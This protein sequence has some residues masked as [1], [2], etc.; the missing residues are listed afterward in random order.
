MTRPVTKSARIPLSMM[1]TAVLHGRMAG[2]HDH[3]TA[4]ADKV[5]SQILAKKSC[6]TRYH[7]PA[8]RLHA[9]LVFPVLRW[10]SAWRHPAISHRMLPA[11]S[12]APANAG[13]RWTG[14][15]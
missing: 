12:A 14:F 9:D 10:I 6:A 8:R 11:N 5:A 4:D 7:D 15:T 3:L 2:D 13:A 1:P